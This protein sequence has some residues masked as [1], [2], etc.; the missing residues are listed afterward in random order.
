M[1]ADV[2]GTSL[3]WTEAGAA[4]G[5]PLVLVH[6]F[7]F[8]AGMWRPQLAEPPAGWRVIAPDLRGFGASAA[9][10]EPVLTMDRFADDIAALIDHLGLKRAVF[11]GLSMGGYILFALL[12]RRPDLVRA[13]ILSDTRAGAD[14]AEARA[15]RLKSAT[16][17]EADGTSAFIEGM[18][19]KLLSPRTLRIAPA[20]QDELR[21]IMRAAPPASVAATLRGLAERADSA[22]TLAGIN[23][24]TLVL[25]GTEDAITP[26]TEARYI[27]RTIRGATLF[28]IDD[29][30]HVPN[31]EQPETFNRSLTT[32]LETVSA[33][34]R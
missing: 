5:Q 12:R 29:A 8:H 28:E 1:Q 3:S 19:P 18:I 7:P 30:G 26:P 17:V 6:G 2:A 11:G 21:T 14:S 34:A 23:V 22:D 16:Q 24:P 15:G 9:A 20:V 33:F 13:L 25:V 4:D 10:A 32:F 27:A 31:L